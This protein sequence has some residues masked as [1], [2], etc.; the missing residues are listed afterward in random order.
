MGKFVLIHG[1]WHGAWC[2]YKV[3]PLLAR[4]GHQ[5]VAPDQPSYGRDKTP[6]AD[7]SPNAWTE[8]IC[9]VL[10]AQTEPV[11]LVGQAVAVPISVRLQKPDPTKLNV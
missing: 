5:V 7:V 3:I 8:S 1:S 4:A 6:T 2:W 11:V 9:Q 10:D